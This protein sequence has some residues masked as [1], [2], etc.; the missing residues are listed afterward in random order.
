LKPEAFSQ[1]LLT[2]MVSFIFALVVLDK[3][4]P[5]PLLLVLGVLCP[6]PMQVIPKL[7]SPIGG[8]PEEKKP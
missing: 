3:P 1:L 6:S 8:A 2:L 4:L 5:P 7:G